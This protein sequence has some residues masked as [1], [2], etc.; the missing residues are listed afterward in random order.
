MIYEVNLDGIVGPTHNYSGL[1]YG[2][3]PSLQN[4]SSVSNPREAA[5][6]GLEKMKFL[7]DLGLI[8]GVL[9][10]HERP[11]LP[12]LRRLGFGGSDSAIVA[13]AFAQAPELLNAVSSAASMWTANAATVSPSADSIDQH[14]HFTAANLS[15]KFHRSIEHNTTA[16]ILKAIFKN[17]IYF[18]HHEVLP[19][20]HFPDEGAANHTRFCSQ[21][22][23]AGVEL[24][25][26]GRRALAENSLAPKTYPAR[27]SYE[28]SQAISRLHQLYPNRTIFTQQHPAAIDAGAFHNDVVAV[29]NLNFFFFHEMAFIGKDA[30]I[31]EIKRKVAETCD[32]EMIFVEVKNDHIPLHEAINAYLFNSQ[33]V[34]VP[35]T[36]M[37][38]IAPIECQENIA[39][40][41]YID[42]MLQSKENPIRKVHYFNLRQSMRNG[43]GPACLRLRVVLNENELAAAHPHIFLNDRLYQKLKG[44]IGKHYRDRLEH[45]DLGDPQLMIESQHALD[46]LTKILQLGPIYDFQNS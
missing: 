26:F 31:E 20:S 45:K 24:F 2:N 1:S 38:L 43:G 18:K 30:L 40:R 14:V 36:G 34:D 3:I 35:D 33:V 41:K 13:T 23:T 11:H 27:Q 28:A 7:A 32:A 46:E 37:C 29:G 12:T 21:Y 5:L 10:P 44:W 15:S 9:P 6:Q 8:Q 39:I 19:S 25:V 42:D 16:K 4:Q 17:P 22:G